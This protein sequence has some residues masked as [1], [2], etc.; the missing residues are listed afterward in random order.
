MF[1]TFLVVA[2]CLDDDLR[3]L[4]PGGEEVLPEPVV[5]P[6]APRREDT[7][8][9]PEPGRRLGQ[10]V[11]LEPHV[12]GPERLEREALN[13]ARLAALQVAHAEVEGDPVVQLQQLVVAAPLVVG[14][15][16]RRGACGEQPLLLGDE[17]VDLG[18]NI[19]GAR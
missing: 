6:P 2:L 17:G 9:Q 16:N 7:S 4:W 11:G 14:G 18:L 13:L 19:R 15:S 5:G 8:H 1:Q 12:P 10:R 3:R